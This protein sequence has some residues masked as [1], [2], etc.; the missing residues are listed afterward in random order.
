[1]AKITGRPSSYQKPV[2]DEICNRIASGEP[3]TK[4]CLEDDMPNITTVF[5]WINSFEAFRAQYVRAR[6]DQADALADQIVQFSDE[7]SLD[8][9]SIAKARLQMEARKWTAGKLRPKKYGDRQI[10]SHVGADDGPIQTEQTTKIDASRLT[11]DDRAAL[12]SL[13]LSATVN[14]EG[15]K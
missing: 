13:L 10:T 6:E 4:I 11:P 15:D 9:N 12:K 8:P 3:L 1:M 14:P 5:R 7:A 2:G